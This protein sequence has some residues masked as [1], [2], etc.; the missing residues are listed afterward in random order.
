AAVS[1]PANIAEGYGRKTRGEYIQFLY[2]AQ[3]SLKELETHLL[4]AIRHHRAKTGKLYA[5]AKS[6]PP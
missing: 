4:L 1:I 2:I 5:K 6:L 3:G